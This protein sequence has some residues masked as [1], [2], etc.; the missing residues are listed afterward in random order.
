MTRS[1]TPTWGAARPTPLASNI[2]ST[3]SSISRRISSSTRG[4]RIALVMSTS[5]WSETRTM[6]RTATLMYSAHAPSPGKVRKCPLDV[7]A[8]DRDLPAVFAAEAVEERRRRTEDI[9]P[10]AISE[11]I[12]HP[13]GLPAPFQLGLVIVLVHV[14]AD[15][16]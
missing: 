6:G 1:D 15:A 3:M 7:C 4:T 9:E 10:G 5:L 14:G 8:P 2:V 11:C 12:R 13:A 16:Q